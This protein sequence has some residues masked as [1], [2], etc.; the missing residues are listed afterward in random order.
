MKNLADRI[1]VMYLGHIVELTT[2]E[3]LF[4]HPMHPYTKLLIDSILIP[5]PKQNKKEEQL[6]SIEKNTKI[7][8]N[9]PEGTLTQNKKN[10]GCCFQHRCNKFIDQCLYQK[11]LLTE[12]EKEHFVACFNPN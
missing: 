2:A 4:S 9:K 10:Q 5:D 3:K 6:K 12:L 11:P 7:K 1:I 8:E